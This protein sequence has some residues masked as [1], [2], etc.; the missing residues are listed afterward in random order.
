MSFSLNN[1]QMEFLNFGS[2]YWMQVGHFE[3]R[4]VI[5]IPTGIRYSKCIKFIY[6]EKARK[7]CK[8]STLLLTVCTVDKSKVEISRNFVAFSEYM[9]FKKIGCS[10]IKS[11]LKICFR[12]ITKYVMSNYFKNYINTQERNDLGTNWLGTIEFLD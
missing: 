9:N 11:T 2:V 6:S 7:F 1:F 4:S 10:W 5:H 3:R 12:T 8:I